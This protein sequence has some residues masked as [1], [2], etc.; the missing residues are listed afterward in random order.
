MS[1]AGRS[2]GES[3]ER[4]REGSPVIAH[5]ALLALIP[6]RAPRRVIQ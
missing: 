5:G 1:P 4:P 6:K 2:R 3:F